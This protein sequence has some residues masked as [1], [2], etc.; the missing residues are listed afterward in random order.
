MN[1]DHEKHIELVGEHGKLHDVSNSQSGESLRTA[2]VWAETAD[3]MKYTREF[4]RFYLYY[5][6]I[7]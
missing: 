5:L 1:T 4:N 2:R 7:K 3:E 6:K